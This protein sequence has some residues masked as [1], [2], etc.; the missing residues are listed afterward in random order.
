STAIRSVTVR[1][2]LAE[3]AVCI[4]AVTGQ[5]ES[6]LQDA[7]VRVSETARCFGKAI[8]SE[9]RWFWWW[10]WFKWY[11]QQF[12]FNAGLEIFRPTIEIRYF[13]GNIRS[14]KIRSNC[15]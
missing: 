15:I 12:Q 5:V 13:Q 2:R 9:I 4:S 11:W 1:K 6:G 10:K 7:T 14:R 8:A 3:S